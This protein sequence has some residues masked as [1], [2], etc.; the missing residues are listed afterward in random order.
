[1]ALLR[2]ESPSGM[3]AKLCT[4]AASNNR[5][6]A[7]Q[8]LYYCLF[9]SVI[10]GCRS[11]RTFRSWWTAHLAQRQRRGCNCPFF[12]C[13]GMVVKVASGLFYCWSLYV[14]ITRKII[15]TLPTGIYIYTPNLKILVYFQSA[16]YV[17]F[18]FC[19]YEKFGI[20]LVY[21]CW[22]DLV[23]T[24]NQNVWYFAKCKQRKH[25]GVLLNMG[26]SMFFAIPLVKHKS[27]RMLVS[28]EGEMSTF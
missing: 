7:P 28:H 4:V 26:V 17:N 23:K 22:N 6:H 19:I 5:D 21:F 20:Y 10:Y 14:T 11:S 2:S 8:L 12:S 13:R 25:S 1:M 27:N 24:I 18:W 15:S 9:V 3:C 16:W